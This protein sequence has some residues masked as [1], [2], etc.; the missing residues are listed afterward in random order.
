MLLADLATPAGI[1]ELVK[2]TGATQSFFNQPERAEGINAV[3]QAALADNPNLAHV[4]VRIMPHLPNCFYNYERG[5]L[6]LGLVNP[7]ALAHELGHANRIKQDGLY[8][9]ILSA[10]NGVARLNNVVAIP[11]ML[12]LRTFIQDPERRNDILNSLAAVSTAVAAPGLMEEAGAS[13]NAIRHSPDRVQ[14]L[15]TL[16]PAFLAHFASS[17][18][19]AAVYEAGS[20]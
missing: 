13:V 17:M 14:S 12:A 2:V 16:G 5:E 7:D 1:A 20:L 6:I 11:T 19:P 3:V 15:K 18:V 9:K 4:K 10:A 8:R